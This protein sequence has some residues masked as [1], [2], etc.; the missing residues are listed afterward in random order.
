MRRLLSSDVCLC[1]TPDQ[2]LCDKS[3][4]HITGQSCFDLV[5]W[6]EAM[7]VLKVVGMKLQRHWEWVRII[8]WG[9]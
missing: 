8:L 6:Y 3:A 5:G 4:N 1:K 2:S 9:W 7:V